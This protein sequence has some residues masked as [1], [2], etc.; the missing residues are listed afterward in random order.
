M[1]G[2]ALGA[3]LGVFIGE[4]AGPIG[5][6]GDVWIRLLQMAILACLLRVGALIIPRVVKSPTAT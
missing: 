6:V 1:I 4:Y 3:G 2:F 5:V